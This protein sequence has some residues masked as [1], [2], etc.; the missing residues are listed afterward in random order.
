MKKALLKKYNA[1]IIPYIAI[2]IGGERGGTH[3]AGYR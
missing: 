1:A 3:A 2:P